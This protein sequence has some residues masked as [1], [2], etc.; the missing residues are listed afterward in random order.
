MNPW[1]AA[2]ILEKNKLSNDLPFLVL[3]EIVH[4]GL[5]APVRLV[6][7]NEDIIWNGNIYQRFP[8]DFDGI[9][10]DGQ[11][12]PSINLK[13][14]NVGGLIESYIQKYNGFCDAEVTI[15]VV[16][17]AHLDQKEAEYVLH[18]TCDATRYDEKWVTFCLS[19][20][21]EF[22]YRFPPN[23]YMR[24]FCKWKYKSVRC[25][26]S[27]MAEPCSGTLATCRIPERFGGEPGVSG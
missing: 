9:N 25:G 5:E 14:S 15:M 12:L 24:D 27:G 20:N 18:L 21:K 22:N 13:V 6:R 23:R 10:E 4:K 19:G 26:Y 1:T 8:F 2:G 17:A 7:N 16:H 3:L 11:E